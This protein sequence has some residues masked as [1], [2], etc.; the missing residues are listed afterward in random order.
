M[1]EKPLN[2]R[3]IEGLQ[4]LYTKL[5]GKAIDDKPEESKEG[6]DSNT[7]QEFFLKHQKDW[8]ARRMAM[9][10][11]NKFL[12]ISRVVMLKH[13]LPY[14]EVQ[15]ICKLCEV[16]VAFNSLIKSTI[17]LHYYV[18][19]HEKTGISIN[20]GATLVATSKA[21][22]GA[23]GRSSREDAEAQLEMLQKT[24]EFLA[25][26]LKESREYIK[27]L[28]KELHG[29]REVIELEKGTKDKAIAKAMEIE[30]EIS[31][32]KRKSHS[33]M[34]ML[35]DH[36][37][38]LEKEIAE[39]D[40]GIKKFKSQ[41]KKLLQLEAKYKEEN[42]KLNETVADLE[43]KNTKKT[44][45]LQTLCDHFFDSTYPKLNGILSKNDGKEDQSISRN[46][47]LSILRSLEP[48]K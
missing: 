18:S 46:E 32:Y 2:E 34:I 48:S 11:N 29:L 14:F 21:K 10:A 43:N 38:D 20:L 30:N 41:A 22:S 45:I 19:L 13:L 7:L 39:K 16:C 26:R 5:T 33:T 47:D 12:R 1:E 8:K 40:R 6:T 28:R 35:E 9:N 44:A 25:G 24:R 31:D 17:F 3:L 15:E 27:T 42:R 37:S 23:G 4:E 36:A